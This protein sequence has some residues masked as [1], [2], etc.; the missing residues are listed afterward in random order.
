MPCEVLQL[1]YGGLP[2]VELHPHWRMDLFMPEVEGYGHWLEIFLHADLASPP[3]PACQLKYALL[4]YDS[5]CRK[6]RKHLH[7]LSKAS[8]GLLHGFALGRGG[9]SPPWH[10]HRALGGGSRDQSVHVE[11]GHCH[12]SVPKL[13]VVLDLNDV[14][15]TK[16]QLANL[17]QRI[18]RRN[19][20]VPCIFQA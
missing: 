2:A 16:N 14:S 15:G 6:M 17:V 11:K 9:L 8:K 20:K 7:S 5:L 4:E 19:K 12:V 18:G 1:R 13:E 10:L 3:C